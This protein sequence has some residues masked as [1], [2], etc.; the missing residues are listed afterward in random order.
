MYVRITPFR[1]DTARELEVVKFTEQQIV[2]AFRQLPG[3]RRY[4]GALDH[5]AGR[6]VAITEWDDL[7]HA[8]GLRGALGPLVQR[9]AAVGVQ[10]EDAQLYD[11][12][13]Q[14]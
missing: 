10:L 14:A 12:V 13:V 3:F 8:E 2:P 11:I 6:G 1:Y 7:Q 9:I 5:D 4:S